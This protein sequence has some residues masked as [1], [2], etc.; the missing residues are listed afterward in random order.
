[1]SLHA[2]LGGGSDIDTVWMVTREPLLLAAD[3]SDL[4]RRLMAMRVRRRRGGRP[5]RACVARPACARGEVRW[6]WL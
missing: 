1:M 6:D 5:A 3:P 4:M 2:V